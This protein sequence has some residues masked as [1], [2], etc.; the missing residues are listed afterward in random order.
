M[1]PVQTYNKQQKTEDKEDGLMESSLEEQAVHNDIFWRRGFIKYDTKFQDKT[2]I[3]IYVV[4]RN[5]PTML[6]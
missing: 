4:P 5:F 6:W 2:N 1:S 3:Y